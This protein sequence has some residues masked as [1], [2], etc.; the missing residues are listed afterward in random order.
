MQTLDQLGATELFRLFRWCLRAK[1]DPPID[2]K[3][4]TPEANSLIDD[5]RDRIL[6]RFPDS[7]EAGYM[8]GYF[9]RPLD[10][11][12]LKALIESAVH[13]WRLCR[14]V[15]GFRDLVAVGVYPFVL[16]A[17]GL[18][19]VERRLALIE[20]DTRTAGDTGMGEAP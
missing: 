1:F 18:T 8:A 19:E 3:A 15:I 12:N 6:N 17:A 9:R 20:Q 13:E 5:L 16:D 2:E 7:R 4:F 11:K 14:S 10:P